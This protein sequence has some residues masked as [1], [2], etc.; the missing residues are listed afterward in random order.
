MFKFFFKYQLLSSKE[1]SRHLFLETPLYTPVLQYIRN[2][3]FAHFPIHLGFPQE[4]VL[5]TTKRSKQFLLTLIRLNFMQEFKQIFCACANS[6]QTFR[7]PRAK[8]R[9]TPKTQ[10]AVKK[11]QQLP[12]KKLNSLR[13]QGAC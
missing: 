12:R 2:L 5:L 4:S 7:P 8:K 3:N 1:P 6:L 13:E 9:K 10:T 11:P